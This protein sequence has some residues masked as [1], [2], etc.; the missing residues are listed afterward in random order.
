M[1]LEHHGK[2]PL[3]GKNCFLAPNSTLIGE[4]SIGD[5]SSVWFGCVVRGDVNDIR[6]GERTNIQDLSML[7]VSYKKA[8]LQ[9]GN[10]VTVGH[11]CVL[12]ACKISDRVLIG[13]GSIIMDDVEIGEDCIIGAGTLLTEGTKIPPRSL[14]IGSPGKVKRSLSTDEIT[15]VSHSA[16]H[17]VKLSQSYLGGPWPTESPLRR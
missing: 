10:D 14:V 6:I 11:H 16:L 7:H 5:S 15:F 9:I 3:I 4:V 17:Y 13:M 1:I 8:N 2:I 12:H